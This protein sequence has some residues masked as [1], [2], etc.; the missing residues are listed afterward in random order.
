MPPLRALTAFEAAARLGSFRMPADELGI[1]RSA[2]SHQIRILEET[3]GLELF[4]RDAR[5]AFLSKAGHLYYPTV[6]DAFDQ[7]E[8]QTRLLR[9]GKADN[10]LTV[11]VYVTVAL[12][13][14]IPRLHDFERR[15]PDM[16]VKL[17]TAYFDWDLDEGHVDCG[18][19]LA[20][21]RV[22]RKS[23]V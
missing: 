5:R 12:K 1:T 6:R 22:D 17:S 7:I 11:Q 8:T 23:V 3:L 2:V 16:K 10:A 15:F 20:R 13:W 14:L 18:L 4:H 19:I 21:N 9:P